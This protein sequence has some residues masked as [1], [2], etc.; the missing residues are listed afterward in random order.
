MAAPSCRARIRFHFLLPLRGRHPRQKGIRGAQRK[1]YAGEEEAA[2]RLRGSLESRPQVASSRTEID[3]LPERTGG[4]ANHVVALPTRIDLLGQRTD[5]SRN[6]C[7][8]S[9]FDARERRCR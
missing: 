3:I 4:C 5:P 7:P 6:L 8:I 9:K 2:T 1:D